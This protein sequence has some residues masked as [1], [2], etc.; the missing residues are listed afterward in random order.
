MI[1]RAPGG[2]VKGRGERG[3]K[4]SLPGD[5]RVYR[6]IRPLA[7][8]IFNF[9]LSLAFSFAIGSARGNGHGLRPTHSWSPAANRCS[10]LQELTHDRPPPPPTPPPKKGRR[11]VSRG[12]ARR[13]SA[14]MRLQPSTIPTQ[15][16]PCPTFSLRGG[17]FCR[18]T[19]T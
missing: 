3:G 17:L 12:R 9:F 7:L 1:G 15:E 2:K 8:L 14:H 5:S 4:A 10:A 18:R 13:A 16:R 19:K 11:V 6:R